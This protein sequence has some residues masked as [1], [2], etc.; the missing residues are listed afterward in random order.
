MTVHEYL[1]AAM[2]PV[3]ADLQTTGGPQPVVVDTEWTEDVE[4][5]SAML[6]SPDGGGSGIWIR[7]TDDKAT[8]TAHATDQ[9]QGWAV[10]ELWGAAAPTNWPACPHHPETHPLTASANCGVARWVCPQDGTGFAAV[11]SLS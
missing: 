6:R 3:L 4:S 1:T 7:L 2:A 9:V 10:E 8:A 5:A 11:G